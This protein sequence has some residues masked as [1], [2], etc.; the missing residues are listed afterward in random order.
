MLSF[1]SIVLPM[2]P[3][4]G[5]SAARASEAIGVLVQVAGREGLGVGSLVCVV[6]CVG[7]L[8]ARFCDREDWGSVKEGVS[9][10]LGYLVDRRPKVCFGSS[11]SYVY[12]LLLI[13]HVLCLRFFLSALINKACV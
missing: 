12:P 11:I 7:L 6:K 2:V 8:L 1:L 5:F 3:E 9:V 4:T 10:L 13:D